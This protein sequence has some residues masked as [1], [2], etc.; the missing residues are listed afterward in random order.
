MRY[1]VISVKKDN[2][3]GFGVPAMGMV[4]S[5]DYGQEVKSLTVRIRNELTD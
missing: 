5:G 1:A 4:P 2:A 3:Y